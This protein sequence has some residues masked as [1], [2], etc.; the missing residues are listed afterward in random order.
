MLLVVAT[1]LGHPDDLSLRAL[2]TL[3][4]CDVVICESTKET[5]KLLRHH[6]ITGKR[7]EVLDEHTRREELPRLVELCETQTC[8]LVSDCGT[9]GFCDPGADLVQSCRVRGVEV[10]IVPGPS[11]LAAL[12][13]ASG[14]K[15]AEFVFVGFVPAENEARARKW[16]ELSSEKRALVV[17]DT[18]YR[19]TKT[20][21]DLEKFFPK[22]HCLIVL[23]V[24]LESE[25]ILEGVPSLLLQSLRGQKAEFI[26]LIKA[27]EPA[28]QR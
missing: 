24:S 10:R 27:S 22:R 14:V 18:P 19:L 3:K 4:S 6:G 12:L 1:P 7:F 26:V 5:S 2:Q 28:S 8:V 11:S 21:E 16:K 23:D 20:L 13:S 25:A 9:P 17:M 15:T